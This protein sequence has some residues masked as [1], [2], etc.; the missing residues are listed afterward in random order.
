MA[1]NE[2][3]GLE[4][5]G[6]MIPVEEV[7]KHVQMLYNDAREFAGV[8]HGM[9]RSETFRLNWPDEDVF[10][11]G[12]W[13]NFVE[14][15]RMMYAERLGDP[16]TSPED[17]HKMHLALV[18]ETMISKGAEVDNRLQIMPDSQ[19]FYGEKSENRKIMEKFGGTR[20]LRA[21]LLNSSMTKH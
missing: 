5:N 19:Q 8:F 12:N 2:Q 11:A 13:K 14:P 21:S 3:K 17:S 9:E 1:V 16:K 20:S 15:V 10:A 18:L 7:R 4:V 6:E